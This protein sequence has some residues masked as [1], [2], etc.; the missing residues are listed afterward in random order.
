MTPLCLLGAVYANWQPP[1]VRRA[2]LP[3][4]SERP[5]TGYP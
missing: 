5:A 2:W 1:N 3:V 4:V